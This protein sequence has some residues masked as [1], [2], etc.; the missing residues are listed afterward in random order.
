MDEWYDTFEAT[1]T[2][3]QDDFVTAL[4][5]TR[6]KI[7][8]IVRDEIVTMHDS[9][10]DPVVLPK[11]LKKILGDEQDQEPC[12]VSPEQREVAARPKDAGFYKK[13]LTDWDVAQKLFKVEMDDY[14]KEEQS[15]LGVKRSIKFR[16]GHARDWFNDMS[17]AERKEVEDAKDKWNK[18]GAPAESQAMYRKRNL[19]KVLDDFTEQ[20]RRTMG[21]RIVMLV[22]HK[23]KSDQTLSVAVHESKPLNSNKPFT[24]SSRGC[25]EWTS[26][27]FEKFAEWSKLEFYPEDEE[28]KSDEEDEDNDTKEKLPELVLDNKGYAKLPSRAGIHTR[29]QQE[30][31][32]RIFHASYKVFTKSSK[33]VP[34]REVIANLSLYLDLDCLPED[35]LLRDPSHLRASDIT[36]LWDHWE[37]RRANKDRLIIFLA[38]K[39]GNMSKESLKNVV[40]YQGNPKKKDYKEIDDKD[41]DPTSGKISTAHTDRPAKSKAAS[42]SSASTRPTPRTTRPA[43]SKA[44]SKASASMHPTPC[45][46]GPAEGDSSDEESAAVTF[47]RRT[48]GPAARP[49]GAQDGAPAVIP[50]KDRVRFLKSL[51]SH[52]GYLLLVEGIRDLEKES[53]SDQQKGWPTWATWSWEGSYLPDSVH[54]EDG[55]VLK[56]LETATSAKITSLA[57]GMRVT[58]GLGLLLRECKRAIEYEA[59]EPPQNAPTYI[60]TSTLGIKILVLVEEAVDTVRGGIL[61]LVKGR[62][63]QQKCDMI[64]VGEKRTTEEVERSEAEERQKDQERSELEDEQ[65]TEEDLQKLEEAKQTG[66][67]LKEDIPRLQEEKRKLVEEKQRLVEVNE[68]LQ[69]QMMEVQHDDDNGMDEAEPEVSVKVKGKKRSK[70]GGSGKPSKVAKT[71]DIRR[72]SRSRLPSKKAMKS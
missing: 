65:L 44:A 60:G 70:S 21:C 68:S 6:G 64:A 24:Q 14:D 16:M 51:S 37:V 36:K 19:K 43:E 5:D 15:K 10:E 52:N 57:S 32:R 54:S 69:R 50:M 41:K 26:D 2:H 25:K 20:I 71:D 38:G 12:G 48:A 55:T 46:T 27:G 39:L 4:P 35:F 3:H 72:S 49:S 31:V 23:K 13:E 67:T 18:E 33:P 34:W 45:I 8:K 59:D 1:L 28:D 7:L 62:E 22:S 61:R 9:L 29:G 53:N 30:L 63:G 58:L 40:P 66:E 47:A 11:R 17:R 56:F 42:K